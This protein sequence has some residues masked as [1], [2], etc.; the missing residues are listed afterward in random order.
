MSHEM[1]DVP[2]VLPNDVLMEIDRQ[3]AVDERDDVIAKLTDCLEQLRR[4]G[5][6]D[7]RIARYV[8]IL[9]KGNKERAVDFADEA[10]ED[11]RNIIFWVENPEESRLDTPEKIEEF[12]EMM[13][14]LG[15][16]RDPELD[17]DQQRIREQR[18]V[19]KTSKP[20]WRF[21]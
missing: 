14:W 16:E 20:W 7:S 3:F 1:G 21:W 10:V 5:I 13:E 18:D 11:C 15:L 17:R 8:L 19:V 6:H 4:R 12:Q 2:G 9:A